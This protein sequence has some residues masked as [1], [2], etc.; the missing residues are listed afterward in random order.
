[1]HSTL[2]LLV[3]IH[4]TA[5]RPESRKRKYDDITETVGNLENPGKVHIERPALRS[6]QDL[7]AVIKDLLNLGKTLKDAGA[8][9]LI[10]CP[11]PRH[12]SPSCRREDHFGGSFPH[13]KYLM[14]VY[15]LATFIKVLPGLVDVGILHPG[16]V[17]GWRRPVERRVVKDDGVHLRPSH[18]DHIFKTTLAFIRNQRLK[19]DGSINRK[20][21]LAFTLETLP[22]FVKMTRSRGQSYQ[23]P[24]SN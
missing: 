1:M 23:C 9:V 14:T 3:D 17:L 21:C 18:S 15:E 19:I 5:G 8:S 10:I 2:V 4:T 24:K 13:E 6:P 7:V 20:T 22:E 16:E 12:F 11:M